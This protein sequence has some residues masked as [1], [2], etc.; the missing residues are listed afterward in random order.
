V[1]RWA[2]DATELASAG[3]MTKANRIGV[4]RG[5]TRDRGVRTVSARRRKASVGMTLALRARGVA[6]IVGT[7]SAVVVT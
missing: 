5:A 3:A 7:E 2:G 4:S 1:E 6:V